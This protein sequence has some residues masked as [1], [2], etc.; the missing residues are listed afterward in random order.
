MVTVGSHNSIMSP[1]ANIHQYK[2]TFHYTIII[3][4][5]SLEE[6][7]GPARNVGQIKFTIKGATISKKLL[8]SGD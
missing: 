7:T 6:L 1:R 2:N 3:A 8:S 4:I 5:T